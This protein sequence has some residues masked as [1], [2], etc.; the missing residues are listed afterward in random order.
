MSA[1]RVG[2]SSVG[3]VAPGTIHPATLTRLK[4]S[5]NNRRADAKRE[6]E[7]SPPHAYASRTPGDVAVM[8]SVVG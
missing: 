4:G 5:N 7:V 2:P 6:P 1:G 8:V 3:S